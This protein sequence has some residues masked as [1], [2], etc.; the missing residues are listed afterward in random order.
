MSIIR[1]FQSVFFFFWVDRFQSVSSV[2]F[3]C[4][5]DDIEE[6]VMWFY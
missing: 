5:G 3:L 6:Y 4:A 2:F 1:V